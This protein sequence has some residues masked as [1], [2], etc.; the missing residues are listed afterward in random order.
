MRE[1]GVIGEMH[2]V[3]HDGLALHDAPDAPQSLNSE[4]GHSLADALRFRDD[5]ADKLSSQKS[6]RKVEI[7]DGITESVDAD[8]SR[9]PYVP[10]DSDSLEDSEVHVWIGDP[11]A[12]LAPRSSSSSSQNLAPES[13]SS[14]SPKMRRHQ[15]QEMKEESDYALQDWLRL[16][17][18]SRDVTEPRQARGCCFW[19]EEV[20]YP[21]HVAA[22]HGDAETVRLLL[23][24]GADAEQPTSRGRTARQVAMETD[25]FGSHRAVLQM[26]EVQ[27]KVMGFSEAM[28]VMM[29]ARSRS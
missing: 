21:I 7:C 18:F 8:G 15:R 23:A 2:N 25:F 28:Q 19:R 20:V 12:D 10:E 24:A 16:H 27:V 14:R 22:R 29:E 13:Q 26:L 5:F 9:N 17:A 4:G 1:E 11:D 6:S 3:Q